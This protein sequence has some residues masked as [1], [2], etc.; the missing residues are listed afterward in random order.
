MNRY[1]NILPYNY[2]RVMLDENGMENDYINASYIKVRF[3]MLS[4]A[5][6]AHFHS[7]N[8]AYQHPRVY[9][10][11]QGPKSNTNH[12]FWRMVLQNKVESIVMLSSFAEKD[13]IEYH[14]Y[15]PKLNRSVL[16]DDVTVS[17]NSEAVHSTFVKR[18]MTVEKVGRTW[19]S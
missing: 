17:C 8:Q 2:N 12:D 4:L 15:F 3:L 19:S 16:F 6:K 9:I 13:K 10:A 1:A 5:R 18:V 14:N 11:A 7:L